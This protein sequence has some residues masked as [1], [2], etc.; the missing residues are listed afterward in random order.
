M[1][2]NQNKALSAD[3]ACNDRYFSTQSGLLPLR[4]ALPTPFIAPV[5]FPL[6]AAPRLIW[7]AF[8]DP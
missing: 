5:Q 3:L 6:A 2:R 1:V 7:L 8:T 4:L